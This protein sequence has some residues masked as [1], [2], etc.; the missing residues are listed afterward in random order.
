MSVFR[1]T[2]LSDLSHLQVLIAS[3]LAIAGREGIFVTEL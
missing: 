3:N 1:I 2:R